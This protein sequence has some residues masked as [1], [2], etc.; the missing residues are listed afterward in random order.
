MAIVE[1][2]LGR[3][4]TCSMEYWVCF[5]CCKTRGKVVR[6]ETKWIYEKVEMAACVIRRARDLCS[7]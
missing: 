2:C 6:M 1:M 4:F 3:V 5:W 7:L